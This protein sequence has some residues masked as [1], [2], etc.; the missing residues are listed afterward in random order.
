MTIEDKLYTI[1]LTKLGYI[2]SDNLLRII[3]ETGGGRQVFM[4]RNDISDIIPGCT[5]RLKELIAG[6]WSD[7]LSN[8]E[9]ELEFCANNGISII[10][11]GDADYPVR[12]N[13]C[14][15]APVVLYYKGVS[16]LNDRHVI[17]IV[18]TRHCTTYG[19]DCIRRFMADLRSLCPNVLVVSGLAYG[20]DVNAHVQALDN[21]FETVG[22]LAHGLDTLYPAVHKAVAAR[23]VKQGGLISE[24]SSGTKIDKI[25]F[26]Q[27][28]RIVAGMTDATII[29]ESAAHGGGLITVRIAQ[30]YGRET[31]AFPGRAGDKYSEGCNSLIRDNRAMLL[32][33]AADFVQSMGWH[34]D[35]LL[36]KAK[37][38]GIERD[39]FPQL[40]TIQQ[41]VADALRNN[42][43]M[44]LNPLLVTTGLSIGTLNQTLFEL[45]MMGIV[46]PYAG[47]T[48]H[49]L[50]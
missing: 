33:S 38:K 10:C 6:D 30:D 34:T 42:G 13:E 26:I 25:N 16:N 41:C 1:A 3:Q 37:S 46:K 8:A 40:T 28:N 45:E 39:L 19:A 18:G 21:G 43:D 36:T 31:F 4:Q 2:S 27:R 23:M 32:T 11:H 48:Y 47:G 49:L 29:V 12:L 20:V 35:A 14:P 7:A 17:S 50:T 5:Q 44:Q 15:D 9:A 22:V 24:F